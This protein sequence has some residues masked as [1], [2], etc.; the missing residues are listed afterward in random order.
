M[1]D[2]SV[3]NKKIK[4]FRS[5][6]Q[7]GNKLKPLKLKSDPLKP[8]KYVAPQPIPK[9]RKSR[10]VPMPRSN[11]YQ[12]PIAEKVKKLIDEITPFYK[13]EA[14]YVHFKKF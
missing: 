1:L 5:P 13:P 3:P 11:L 10:P 14:T 9:P 7:S 6:S 4:F 12:K 2:S 8:T